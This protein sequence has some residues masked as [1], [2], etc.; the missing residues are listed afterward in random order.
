MRWIIAAASVLVGALLP[1]CTGSDTENNESGSV[2][3]YTSADDQLARIVADAFTEQTGIEV[4]ILGDTEATK[5][6]GLVARI[7]AEQDDPVGDVWWSSEPMGTILLAEQGALEPGAMS[8]II[9]E[10][11][12]GAITAEDKS[13]AGFAQRARVIVYASDRVDEA[14]TTMR[15]LTDEQLKDRVGIARPQ[16]GTTRGHMALLHEQWGGQAFESWLSA[17]SDNGARLYDGNMSVVRAV[18]MGEIDVGL[19]DTDD[20]YA[21]QNNG[22]KVE[23]AYESHDEDPS[24]TRYPSFG[25]T[26]I[27]NTVGVIRGAPNPENARRLAA[28]LIS[29]ACERIIAQSAS[30]NLPVDP[31][32]R[33]EFSDEAGIGGSFIDYRGAHK[34]VDEA[35]DMCERTLA[36]P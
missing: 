18:A 4:Q 1:A 6:T 15:A 32:V 35:M 36:G 23:L 33:A 34:S 31:E 22:W 17:L 3:L 25:P 10:D 21:G 14:P 5:T 27:P 12:P 11:W 7:L 20:V 13:W 9:P 30:R 2:V 8:Q 24:G 26:T 29:G 28:F 19:T 16:F